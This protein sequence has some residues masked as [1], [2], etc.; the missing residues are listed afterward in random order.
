M[1][2]QSCCLS[3]EMSFVH[4]N[5]WRSN[6]K[7]IVHLCSRVSLFEKFTVNRHVHK[8]GY[9]FFL[10]SFR[11][12][13]PSMPW[14]T[15]NLGFIGWLLVITLVSSLINWRFQVLCWNSTWIDLSCWWSVMLLEEKF[16]NSFL[17]RGGRHGDN[18]SGWFLNVYISL[19]FTGDRSHVIERSMN[20]RTG[21]EE[22][23]QDFINLDE[24]ECFDA[25]L[26]DT[27]YKFV[28]FM[29]LFLGPMSMARVGGRAGF[30]GTIR[31]MPGSKCCAFFTPFRPI[32]ALWVWQRFCFQLPGSG[33]VYYHLTL[34][35]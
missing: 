24:S 33:T 6:F 5:V 2:Y 14:E 35:N 34:G 17:C 20:R 27:L 30:G 12:K 3:C 31:G 16:S 26:N 29:F 4:R 11:W 28:N 10:L 1:R 8:T 32:L 9:I 19:S 18:F 15:Q 13:K 21:E 25:V 22:R 7:T 23:K